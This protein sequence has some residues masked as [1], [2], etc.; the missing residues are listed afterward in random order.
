M[1]KKNRKKVAGLKI[2]FLLMGFLIIPSVSAQ[3]TILTAHKLEGVI[4][5]DGHAIEEDWKG[6][7]E[8]AITVQDGS[9]GKVKI[10]LKALFDNEYIYILASWP[11]P[12]QSTGKDKW[13]FNG[14]RW[15]LSGDEDRIAFI[16]NIA[17]SIHGFNIGG[18]AMLCHGDRMH[19]N[20]KGEL[21]D[22][23]QWKASTTNPVGYADDEWI[24][25]TVLGGYTESARSAAIYADG[26]ASDLNE[27]FVKNINNAGNGPRYYEPNPQDNL[28]S[29]FIFRSEVD[30]GEA[31]EIGDINFNIGDS[32]PGYILSR[33]AG[34]RG[35]IDAQGLWTSGRW[36]VELRRKL[37][38]G[39]ENDVLFDVT[40]TYR[41]GVAVM[42]NSGGF[43]AYGMGHSFDL[44]ARTL[45]FGG[46]GSEEVT[47]LSLIKD[48]LT[49]AQ[50]QILNNEPEK[51]V[52]NV[53]DALILYNEIS[54][55]V[56]NIDHELY[57]STKNQFSDVNRIPTE[58]GIVTLKTAIDDTILTFQ[59]KREPAEAT[60]KLKLLVLWGKIQLFTLILLALF[61]IVPIY[62][63]IHVGR[64][65][66]FRRLS[67]F[68]IVFVVP[69]LFEGVGRIGILL[70]IS[71]LQN[72]SFLTNELA[73]LQ[74]AILMFFGLIIAKSGFEEVE[75]SMKSLEF[76][77]GK[78][79]DDIAQ[80]KKLENELRSSEKRYRGIFEASPF[81][82][83]EVQPD[84]VILNCNEAASKIVDCPNGECNCGYIQ[85]FI[86]DPKDR[87]KIIG[88]LKEGGQTKDSFMKFKN[89][90]G[91]EL[92]VSL[93]L[94]TNVDEK[95]K[96]VRSEIAIM[97][98]TE[99]IRA[100]EERK[101][102]EKE[103]VQSEKLAS[104]GK[105][106]LGFAHEISNPLTNIQLATEILEKKTRSRDVLK[107]LDVIS[108]NVDMASSVVRNL[109][110][111]SRQ[112]QLHISPM[113]LEG[114]LEDAIEMVSPRLG[115]VKIVKKFVK[116]PQIDGDSKQLKQVFANII[117]NAVQAMSNGGKLKISTSVE[118][119]FA[120]VS[121]KDTGHGIS[122][123][124]LKNIFDPFF[125]TKDVGSGTGLGLSLAYGIVKNHEGDIS[126]DSVV[127]KGTTITI[128][129]PLSKG[130]GEKYNNKEDESERV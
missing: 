82:I 92:T 94:E 12:S 19:T 9:I 23:W 123:E 31:I 40:K 79:E 34:N 14:D 113:D 124:K 20:A 70:K 129:F 27:G 118:G 2:L 71:F 106:A 73:T 56:A 15:T 99:R 103:L 49:V 52:S 111:F 61:S 81:G 100:E 64:K 42:D 28:D 6:A 130:N 114:V 91:E 107:R 121:F 63:A 109:L 35:N 86:S 60:F 47:R 84:G 67:I 33:P 74:W 43:E 89:S 90:S 102:L 8:F 77:S 22:M 98:V 13:T 75:E 17:D 59:G 45:E 57:L 96:P 10:S 38:T 97:D 62:M 66:T 95:G 78:L 5:L 76:Y 88:I 53:G 117:I 93:S 104:T 48:Y 72:F 24:D 126:V 108:K 51:A 54:G 68:I 110:D 127:G 83:F 4:E 41:F 85:D 18:C 29:E 37:N 55:D 7:D 46:V 21:G 3:N 120:V 128:R 50:A 25:D 1:Y 32:V 11:D 65:P 16:W 116:V 36:Q 69:L 105:L 30:N 87:E 125:T 119:S 58:E 44:G 115:D 80:M 39:F 122:K 112:S 101:R 26:S